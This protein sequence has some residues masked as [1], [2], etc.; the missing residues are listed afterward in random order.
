M[1]SAVSSL[2]LQPSLTITPDRWPT[3][4]ARALHPASSGSIGQDVLATLAARLADHAVPWEF[5]A[6]AVPTERRYAR[7]LAAAALE[8]WLICWPRGASLE[9]HD[10]GP[11]AGAFAPSCRVR[12]RRPP[13]VEGDRAQVGSA[14]ARSCRSVGTRPRRG[15]P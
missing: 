4:V 10:H 11:S 1:P 5:A 9:L 3:A 12:W 13:S 6:D 2:T 7:L 14:P 15:Q 8:A